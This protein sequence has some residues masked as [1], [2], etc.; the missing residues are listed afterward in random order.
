MKRAEVRDQIGVQEVVSAA[1]GTEDD[2]ATG[3][4]ATSG[5]F[6]AQPY[7]AAALNALAPYVYAVPA[8]RIRAVGIWVFADLAAGATWPGNQLTEALKIS[9]D[10][11]TGPYLRSGHHRPTVTGDQL[12]T[13]LTWWIRRVND[14]LAI[15][16]DPARFPDKGQQNETARLRAAYDALDAM[17]GMRLPGFS[18]AVTPSTA[19]RAYEWLDQHLPAAVAA[20]ALPVCHRGVEALEHVKDG[21][22]PG[23]YVGPN[24]LVGLP[25]KNGQTI[26]RSWDTATAGYLRLDRN[27][28][29][30]FMN[31]SPEDKAVLLSHAGR[32]P[33]GLANIALLWLI[34]LLAEPQ[35]LAAKMPT[36]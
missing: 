17:E 10:R 26:D 34:R 7:L 8:P 13:F 11:F 21:F 3:E 12:H 32:L 6:G 22:A 24:G 15:A 31:H 14:V 4:V 25:G 16:T 23:R 27:S 18:T 19:R 29:H 5:V 2:R 35:Q 36:V 20:V 9:D 33:R 28:A 1:E 30:S